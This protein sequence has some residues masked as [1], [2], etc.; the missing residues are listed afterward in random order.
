MLRIHLVNSISG[1]DQRRKRKLALRFAGLSFVAFFIAQIVPTLA[2]ETNNVKELTQEIAATPNALSPESPTAKVGTLDIGRSE[3]PTPE[4]SPPSKILESEPRAQSDRAISIQI[5]S[6]LS[7]DPRAQILKLPRI[8]ALG[9]EYLLVC[10]QAQNSVLD[11]LAKG[12]PDDISASNLYLAGDLTSQIVIS[13]STA[14]VNSALNSGSG[15]KVSSMGGYLSNDKVNFN[16]V[17]TDKMAR[18]DSLCSQAKP[19]NSRTLILEPLALGL[20]LK[21]GEVILKR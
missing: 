13:G 9:P 5:P 15:A 19:S 16:F 17:A 20:E 8:T 21:K 14:L 6:K 1:H 7:V 3:S 18:D 4:T 10:I 2:D 12:I 11:I